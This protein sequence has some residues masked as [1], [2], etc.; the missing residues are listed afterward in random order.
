MVQDCSAI[1]IY[2]FTKWIRKDKYTLL[3]QTYRLFTFLA[4]SFNLGARVGENI[5]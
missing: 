5:T 1:V 4:H 3:Y 2:A